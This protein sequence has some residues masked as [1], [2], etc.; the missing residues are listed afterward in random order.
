MSL[1]SIRWERALRWC[2]TMETLWMTMIWAKLF[3]QRHHVPL[4]PAISG[5]SH[6]LHFT[7]NRAGF[8]ASFLFLEPLE[9]VKNEATRQTNIKQNIS[10]HPLPP[11]LF[12]FVFCVLKHFLL[13]Q[14]KEVRRVGVESHC[15]CGILSV[16]SVQNR[17][18]LLKQECS[19]GK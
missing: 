1:P 14:F 10:A 17:K 12:P 13:P 6:L 15:I 7:L 11:P 5:L 18:L 4:L 19:S 9:G 2:P 16:L 8:H 3:V